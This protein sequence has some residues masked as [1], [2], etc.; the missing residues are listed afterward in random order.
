MP[1]QHLTL[2]PQRQMD[3]TDGVHTV[4]TSLC[5]STPSRQHRSHNRWHVRYTCCSYLQY[6]YTFALTSSPFQYK[7]RLKSL[8]HQNN[9]VRRQAKVTPPQ[10][11]NARLLRCVHA[12][13]AF[14]C[15][16][17]FSLL[18]PRS[19]RLPPHLSW[20]IDAPAVEEDR[21]LFQHALC[22]DLAIYQHPPCGSCPPASLT[23]SLNTLQFPMSQTACR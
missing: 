8:N 21:G 3:C 11:T 22:I 15:L 17:R 2:Q 7:I 6:W 14:V 20:D 23:L 13:L 19:Q 18:V 9:T 1:G 4:Y 12:G 16:Y 10:I 5:C